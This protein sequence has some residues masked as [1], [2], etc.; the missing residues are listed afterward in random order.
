MRQLATPT[1]SAAGAIAA[2]GTLGI[3]IPPSTIMV[4]YG[5]MTETNIG[6]L[7]A[8]GVLSGILAAVLLCLAVL[9][10]R[11]ARPGAGPPAERRPGPSGGARCA[12]SG[13]VALLFVVVIGGI[14]G[15]VFTA[16]E[17]AGSARSAPSCSP[18]R[19]GPSPGGAAR[20]PARVG[21]DHGHAVPDPDRRAGVRQLHQLH[22]HAGDLQQLVARARLRPSMVIVAI[23]AVYVILGTAMEE[24]SMILLTVPVFFP[25]WSASASTR[26]GSAS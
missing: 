16:T 17:G 11:L 19:A 2:G 5:I 6:K 7:F 9:G 8:A 21:A 15:G 22:H 12:A 23:C 18:W 24:L 26:S 10:H 14:Y 1:S 13:A 3:L 4:I 20:R 25:S